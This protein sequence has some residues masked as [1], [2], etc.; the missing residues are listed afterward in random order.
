MK[1]SVNTI[2]LLALF[3]LIWALMI[4]IPYLFFNYLA[5]VPIALNK[6]LDQLVKALLAAIVVAL[7]LLIWYLL[8]IYLY[9]STKPHFVSLGC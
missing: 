5:K 7:W 2:C 6:T 4:A 3:A 8:G 9:K 1:I